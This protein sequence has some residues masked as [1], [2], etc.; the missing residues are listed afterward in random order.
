[1]KSRHSTLSNAGLKDGK[2]EFNFEALVFESF[3]Y[4]E[5]FNSTD[6]IVDVELDESTLMDLPFRDQV[7]IN[8]SVGGTMSLLICQ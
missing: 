6:V 1:M 5:D 2:H 7:Q 8:V 4:E 3:G